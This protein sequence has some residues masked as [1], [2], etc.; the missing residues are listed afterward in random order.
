MNQI[1]QTVYDQLPELDCK[2]QC[3]KACTMVPAHPLEI[4]EIEKL[5]GRKVKTISGG[6]SMSYKNYV[7]LKPRAGNVEC[8]Y[9]RRN[10]CS[11]YEARPLVCRFYGVTEGL[12][13]PFGCKP[14]KLLTDDEA[15]AIIKQLSE[16]E[17]HA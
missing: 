16:I 6:A 15:H 13:C 17:V 11:I 1:L 12:R 4:L 10:A 8:R 3:G 7:I 5:T 14:K 9:F 2:R